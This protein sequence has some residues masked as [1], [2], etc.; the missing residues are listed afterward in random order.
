MWVSVAEITDKLTMGSSWDWTYC[1]PVDIGCQTLLLAEEEISLWRPGAGTRLSIH[2]IP[3]QCEGIVISRMT[4]PFG[5]ENRNK[6]AGPPARRNLRSLKLLFKPSRGIS[7]GPECYPPGPKA[8]ENI[9]SG[10]L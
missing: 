1:A 4:N 10:A 6:P 7:E 8:H 5:V 2:M 9:P 3:A